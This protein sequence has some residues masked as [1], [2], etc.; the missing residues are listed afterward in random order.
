[1]PSHSPLEALPL[2]LLEKIFIS[3]HNCE[4]PFVSQ[5]LLSLL[6][7]P[8]LPRLM[9]HSMLSSNIAAVQSDL[10]T[11]RFLT[12]EL[13]DALTPAITLPCTHI[14]HVCSSGFARYH[15]MHRSP[16]AAAA[17]PPHFVFASGTRLCPR[18]LCGKRPGMSTAE[19]LATF[20]PRI[21]LLERLIA[22][23][24]D[25]V[26][27]RTEPLYAAA[28]SAV[29][30]SLDAKLPDLVE[31]FVSR[32]TGPQCTPPVEILRDALMSP[33][34]DFSTLGRLLW[35][36]AKLGRTRD[37]AVFTDAPLRKW[38]A[39]RV[40]EDR[41][42]RRVEKAREE[43]K[44][45]LLLWK[46]EWLDSILY[47]GADYSPY[48]IYLWNR[49]STTAGYAIESVSDESRLRGAE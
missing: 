2:E 35:S 41:R 47:R 33:K 8:R 9:A 30:H 15:I 11:R 13:F 37:H 48:A 7:S 17:D 22:G 45:L 25:I 28:M 49:H 1:M 36:V 21:M 14:S 26:E 5:S 19:Y 32:Y 34:H 29:Q 39:A 23:G 16:D 40:R 18:L 20:T 31:L 46:G 12:L 4:L 42:W 43:G 38:V 3:S 6:S 27:I 44:G 24:A 10:L